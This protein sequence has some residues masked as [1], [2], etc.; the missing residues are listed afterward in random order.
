LKVG[1][2]VS[3]GEAFRKT[4]S[5]GLVSVGGTSPSVG[6]AGGYTQGTGHGLTVSHFGLGVDQ[7]LEWEV[8][9]AN[10]TLVTATPNNMYSDLYWAISGGG[11]GTFAAVVSLTLKVHADQI[12]TAVNLTWSN[13]GMTQETYYDG[14]QSFMK[15]LPRLLEA[16]V[17]G[18]WVNSNTSFTVSPFVGVGVTKKAM[19]AL[20]TPLLQDLTSLGI[21]YSKSEST[22]APRQ[23]Y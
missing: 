18:N 1:A 11:G 21:R 13:A 20:Y 4:N 9:T 14:I 15:N 23:P 19:D 2:G 16:G 3:L 6:L 7:A 5:A 8:I 10:G 12:T 22:M 17:G